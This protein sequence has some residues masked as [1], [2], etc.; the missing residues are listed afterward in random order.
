[1]VGVLE[2]HPAIRMGLHYSGPL[3]EWLRAE[4]PDLI[5]RIRALVDREQ[6][7]VLGGPAV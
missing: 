7:E 5:A 2:R 4:H 6:V 3:L 1:M